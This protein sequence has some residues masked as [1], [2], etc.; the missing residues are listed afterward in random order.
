MSQIASSLGMPAFSALLN[1]NTASVVTNTNTTSPGNLPNSGLPDFTPNFETLMAANG[2][3]NLS[4][5]QDAYTNLLNGFETTQNLLSGIMTGKLDGSIMRDPNL[6]G[7]ASNSMSINP[8]VLNAAINGTNPAAQNSVMQ[9]PSMQA[10]MAQNL[11]AQDPN[12]MAAGAAQQDPGM[13]VLTDLQNVLVNVGNTVWQGLQ[14]LGQ[15]VNLLQ[16]ATSGASSAPSAPGTSAASSNDMNNFVSNTLAAGDT[17]APVTDP[18]ASSS[19]STSLSS[20]DPGISPSISMDRNA[21][22]S[23]VPSQY[24]VNPFAQ[25]FVK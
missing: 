9:D 20:S 21:P 24:P 17:I 18:S 13:A 1:P 22:L 2:Y 10:P 7:A 14:Q 5:S 15:V 8:N 12:A 11:A 3:N 6:M 19:S 16:Q 25:K 4:Y 23:P